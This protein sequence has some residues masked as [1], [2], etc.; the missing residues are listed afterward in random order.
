[1][2]ERDSEKSDR[3]NKPVDIL[4]D[5]ALKVSIFRNRGEHGDSYAME[6]RRIWTDKQTNEI[7][8]SHSLSG[9]EPL[10]MAH[11]LTKGHDRVAGLREQDKK[12]EQ[13][14]RVERDSGGH[15]D[16]DR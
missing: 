8:E 5:G 16:R 3:G 9:S 15:E 11:L 4:R 12:R 6:G 7:R 2:S 14:A 10:R 1:M 13:S